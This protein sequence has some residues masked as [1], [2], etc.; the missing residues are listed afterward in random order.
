MSKF[1][2][3]SQL[4]SQSRKRYFDYQADIHGFADTLIT[5]LVDYF[6]IPPRQMKLFPV[7]G[8]ANPERGYS[9]KEATLLADDNFW[10]LGIQIDLICDECNTI[11]TQPILINIGIKQEDDRYLAKISQNDKG[12]KIR[13]G[14]KKDFERFYGHVFESIKKSMES[15]LLKFL[16][17]ESTPCRV[18]FLSNCS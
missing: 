18:G 14:E 11:P 10:H 17:K 2:E 1:L 16:E 6:S 13:R 5:G 8:T 4:Y 12:H 15:S 9:V 3:L 7:S